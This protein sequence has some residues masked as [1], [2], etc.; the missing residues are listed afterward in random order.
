MQC[1]VLLDEVRPLRP[2]AD[3]AHVPAQDVEQL[4]QLVQTCASQ[5]P[6]DLRHARVIPAGQNR[7]HS[8]FRVLDH[9]SELV[10]GEESAIL[11]DPLLLVKDGAARGHFGQQGD[12]DEHG[13]RK[14]Q[15]NNAPHDIQAP[16]QKLFHIPLF[17]DKGAEK[18]E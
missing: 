8:F 12:Q 4:R 16:H 13:R 2:R 3:Q 5:E 18:A 14:K 11:T 10:Q 6:A 15:D 7:A 1:F 17:P 9:R